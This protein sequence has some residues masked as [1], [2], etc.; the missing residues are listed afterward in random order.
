MPDHGQQK[1][2]AAPRAEHDA[3]PTM[4]HESFIGLYDVIAEGMTYIDATGTILHANPAFCSLLGHTEDH[5][6]GRNIL[7]FTPRAEREA[8][9]AIMLSLLA[10]ENVS[11]EREKGFV[12]S[13]GHV[14]PARV[15]FWVNRNDSGEPLGIWEVVNDLSFQ[16]EFEKQ[17]AITMEQ[18]RF[19]ADNSE[20]VIWALNDRLEYIYVSPSVERTRGYSPEELL[21]TSIARSMTPESFESVQQTIQKTQQSTPIQQEVLA[22][23]LILKF[24]HKDG[25]SFWAEV[26]ARGMRDSQGNWLGVVGSSRDITARKQVEKK[27]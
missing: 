22:D 19:L 6:K 25:P 7:D 3:D 18:Y 16:R 26:Q 13:D 17:I 12:H 27:T 15:N 24:K 10:G 4:N 14:I 23:Q 8:E 11:L 9:K 1:S 21:G 2:T 20:D 5:L